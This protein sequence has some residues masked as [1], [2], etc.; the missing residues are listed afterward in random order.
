MPKCIWVRLV[1][2]SVPRLQ[3]ALRLDDVL[4]LA[5]RDHVR[6]QLP[7]EMELEPVRLWIAIIG[8]CLATAKQRRNLPR[9][10]QLQRS[11]RELFRVI[12][13]DRFDA[14]RLQPALQHRV[15]MVQQP[16][17]RLQCAVW[18]LRMR[19][20]NLKSGMRAIMR[21]ECSHPNVLRVTHTAAAET[22]QSF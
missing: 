8:M 11:Y 12:V 10:L 22:L 21:L 6:W 15:L 4:E 17:P 18:K 19:K 13:H 16:L 14:M 5:I 2:G 20:C 3:S 1:Q 9:S 7:V